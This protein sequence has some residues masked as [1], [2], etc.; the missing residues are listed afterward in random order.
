M[1][2][3]CRLARRKQDRQDT[4]DV[5]LLAA[6]PEALL[7]LDGHNLLC[8]M[9]GDIHCP[10]AGRII[11]STVRSSGGLWGTTPLGPCVL[12]LPLFL[13]TSWFGRETCTLPPPR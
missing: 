2:S 5:V 10:K 7:P 3:G 1:G 8:Q 13:C 6:W 4:Y 9:A 11:R 12:C